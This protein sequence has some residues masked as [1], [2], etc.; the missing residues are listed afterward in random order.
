MCRLTIGDIEACKD[1]CLTL[2]VIKSKCAG[3]P[4]YEQLER[5]LFMWS[6]QIQRKNTIITDAILTEKTNLL[7]EIA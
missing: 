3:G 2:A 1:K 5:A 7:Y 6:I 4:Q